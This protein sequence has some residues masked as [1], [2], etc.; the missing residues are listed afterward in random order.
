MNQDADQDVYSSRSING[1]FPNTEK[2]IPDVAE[3]ATWNCACTDLDIL[4]PLL[5]QI[6]KFHGKQGRNKSSTRRHCHIPVL[7]RGVN[8]GAGAISP[9]GSMRK[10]I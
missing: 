9:S 5:E 4:I 8:G 1:T 6:R 10:T 3:E 2:V 7:Q